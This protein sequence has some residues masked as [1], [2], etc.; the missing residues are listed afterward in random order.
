MSAYYDITHGE[1]LAI[2]TPR[3][4]KYILSE[5]TVERFVKYG[6][7]VFGIDASLDR[8]EIAGKAIAMTYAFFEEIGIPMHLRDVGIGEEHIDEM[9]HH[10][11]VNEGLENAWVPLTEEDIANIIRDSL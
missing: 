3:W 2:I 1:G 11:A 8:F 7:N 9:A 10:I 5:K 6:V 4:M